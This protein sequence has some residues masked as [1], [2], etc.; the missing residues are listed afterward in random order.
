[1]NEWQ[2][3]YERTNGGHGMARV[4]D[5]I[6]PLSRSVYGASVANDEY[7]EAF[8]KE[9]GLHFYGGVVNSHDYM[10]AACRLIQDYGL[11]EPITVLK[12][13][14]GGLQRAIDG[15]IKLKPAGSEVERRCRIETYVFPR[16]ISHLRNA[17][18]DAIGAQPRDSYSESVPKITFSIR[19]SGGGEDALPVFSGVQ[20]PITQQTILNSITDNLNR[21]HTRLVFISATNTLDSLLL[22][23]MIRASSPNTRVMI[24]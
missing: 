22:L 23:R 4:N 14:E 6:A 8:R 7:A 16:D 18:E 17:Y 20:T 15:A 24:E 12:E 19:D 1:T 5:S 2:R 21:R 11:K 3:Q 10:A 9:T 13:D